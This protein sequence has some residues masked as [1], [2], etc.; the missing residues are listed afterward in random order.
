VSGRFTRVTLAMTGPLLAWLACFSVIYGF[1]AVACAR[2]FAQMR[3][4]GVGVIG[5]VTT[6]AVLATAAFTVWQ[7]AAAMRQYRSSGHSEK[8][9]GF[10]VLSLGGL[11]L[12]GLIL[13]ALP[14]LVIRPVCAGQPEL[15]PAHSYTIAPPSVTDAASHA[16]TLGHP[17]PGVRRDR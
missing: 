8:F 15:L 14:A 7:I 4:A 10:L 3:L 17:L 1:G 2:G 16:T 9:A 13:L 12:L 6:A 5:A 11:G